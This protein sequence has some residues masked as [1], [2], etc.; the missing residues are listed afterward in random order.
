[1]IVCMIP[2]ISACSYVRQQLSLVIR[3]HAGFDVSARTCGVM[4]VV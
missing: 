2:C 4:R 1:M 3:A